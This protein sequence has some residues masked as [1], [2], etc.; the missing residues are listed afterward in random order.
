M[1]KGRPPEARIY[2]SILRE[3]SKLL[4]FWGPFYVSHFYE[5]KIIYSEPVNYSKTTNHLADPKPS[6]TQF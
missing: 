5:K 3:N 6:C 2:K 1:A 4:C